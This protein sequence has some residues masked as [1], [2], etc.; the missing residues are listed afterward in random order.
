MII[1]T[2]TLMYKLPSSCQHLKTNQR[3]DL[4]FRPS[5]QHPRAKYDLCTKQQNIE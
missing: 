1:E 4:N 5:L 2:V 3:D